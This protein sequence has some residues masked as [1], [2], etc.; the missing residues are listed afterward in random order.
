MKTEIS[1]EYS[2]GNAFGYVS[3]NLTYLKNF[4]EKEGISLHTVSA[5]YSEWLDEKFA[6][7]KS[8]H[9][10]EEFRNQGFGT[11]LVNTFLE[12]ALLNEA[13]IVFLIVDVDAQNEFDLV[14]WYEGFDFERVANTN[15]MVRVSQ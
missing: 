5:Q 14:T 8:L 7:L 9:V 3:D 12:E 13:S 15:L 4:L 2:G 1:I 6:I 11:D 10:E